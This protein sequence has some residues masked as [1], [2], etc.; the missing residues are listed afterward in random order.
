[1]EELTIEI[2]NEKDE[3]LRILIEPTP[4]YYTIY[5]GESAV[6]HAV[7]NDEMENRQFSIAPHKDLLIVYAPGL[8][9]N[10]A[11]CHVTKSGI[12]CAPEEE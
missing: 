1:M 7:M 2:C 3:N 10:F 6:V 4:D 8:L 12:R 11:E 9:P 5:P